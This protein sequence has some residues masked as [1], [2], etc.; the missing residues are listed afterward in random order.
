MPRGDRKAEI[1]SAAE[2]LFTSR[3]FH[4]ITLDDVAA[5]ARVGKGTIYRY[6]ENK[7]HLFFE[8]ALQGV[9]ELCD[10]L[11]ER[12][13]QEAPFEERLLD[14]CRQ[15]SA[16]FQSRR[17]LFGMMQSEEARIP[18]SEA[19]V[20]DHWLR[21]RRRLVAALAEII[22]QGVAE[23]QIRRDIPAEVLATFL[24]GML[25]SRA[26]DLSDFSEA[27]HRHELVLDLFLS[28]ASR[29]APVDGE[30]DDRV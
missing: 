8:V 14:A 6:F 2:K 20:R 30:K 5:Q 7:D 1:M 21:Q 13:P 3:R 16:F 12:V 24:L 29:A 25:R 26:R 22:G 28:G 23:G 17:Q 18:W 27:L 10:L 19:S 11:V 4:Q 15:I 9:S